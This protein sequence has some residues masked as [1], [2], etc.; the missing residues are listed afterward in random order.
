VIQQ[1]DAAGPCRDGHP[2]DVDR[3]EQLGENAQTGVDS[4][5]TRR[6][7]MVVSAGMACTTTSRSVARRARGAVEHQ[8]VVWSAD[9]PMTRRVVD[10]RLHR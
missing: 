8:V 4:R 2:R 10:D 9:A 3:R 1:L 6:R 7:R 5:Q